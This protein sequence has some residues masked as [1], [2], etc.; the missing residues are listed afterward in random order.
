M[1]W[2]NV[3]EGLP[4]PKKVVETLLS[5]DVPSI[6]KKIINYIDDDSMWA[7]YL[8]VVTHWRELEMSYHDDELFNSGHFY[9]LGY[10]ACEDYLSIEAN[11]FKER[12]PEFVDWENGWIDYNL[13]FNRKY[14]SE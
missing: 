6:S 14:L 3:K 8:C 11:P 4:K 10:N 2:I 5:H 1:A 13:K 7:N 12:T 9:D